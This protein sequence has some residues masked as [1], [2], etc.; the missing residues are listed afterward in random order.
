MKSIFDRSFKYTPAAATDLKKTFARIKR[1]QQALQRLREA[2]EA[3]AAV[4]VL[5]ITKVTSGGTR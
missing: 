3:E 4:K 5:P 2:A 1:E